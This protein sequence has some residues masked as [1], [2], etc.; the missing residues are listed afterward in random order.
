MRWFARIWSSRSRLSGASSCAAVMSRSAS[1][2]S[3]AA[4]VGA[5]TVIAVVSS[6]AAPANRETWTASTSTDSSG[7]PLATSRI[8]GSMGG[9]STW[10]MTCTIE[11]PAGMSVAIG[12]TSSLILRLPS[13]MLVETFRPESR[14]SKS[15]G[16]LAI[17]SSAVNTVGT[18]WYS[19]TSVSTSTGMASRL[20]MSFAVRKSANAWLLGAKRVTSVW[21]SN[22]A[23][24][25]V[26]DLRTASTSVD[27]TSLSTATLASVGT[28][29]STSTCG[30]AGL[31][32]REGSK[33][34]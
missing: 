34:T 4:L 32:P 25:T 1:S 13:T 31:H 15:A 12:A 22:A 19:S 28:V 29:G 24:A 16:A 5:S 17:A 11:R 26:G 14:V 3:K 9:D 30:R 33:F 27:K 21:G 8:V 6:V 20:G 18:I 7:T 10:L 2:A 23:A